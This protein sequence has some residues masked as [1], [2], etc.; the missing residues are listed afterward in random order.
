MASLQNQCVLQ[1]TQEQLHASYAQLVPSLSLSKLNCLPTKWP[2][3]PASHVLR[4][5]SNI[6]WHVTLEFAGSTLGYLT[7]KALVAKACTCHHY[8]QLMDDCTCRRLLV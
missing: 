7:A 4:Q 3:C 1:A 6:I 8:I 5:H 2:E